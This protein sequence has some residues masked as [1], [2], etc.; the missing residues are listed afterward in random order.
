MEAD[1]VVLAVVLVTL[2]GDYILQLVASVLNY[3]ALGQPMPLE[4]SDVYDVAEYARSGEYTRAK[5]KFGKLHSTFELVVILLFWLP[6]CGFERVDSLVY[7]MV[8]SS[9]EGDERWRQIPRG[10]LFVGILSIA[11]GLLG[12]PWSIYSTFVLEERFG[13]NKTTV[14]T[15]VLDRLKGLALG[16][17]LGPPIGAAVLAFFLYTGPLAWLYCWAFMAAFQ[18]VLMWLLPVLLMPLFYQFTPIPEGPLQDAVK[19]YA[20]KVSFSFGGIFEVDGSTRSQHSNAFFTG[21]GSTKRIAIF[22]TLIKQ[23]ST[24]EIVAVL[25]HE[26]GHEKCGHIVKSIVVSLLYSLVLLYIMSLF[27]AFEPLFSA[28]CVTRPSVYVGLYLFQMLSS[29]IDHVLSLAMMVRSRANEFEADR[30]SVETNADAPSL[31]A[32]LK[33]LSSKNLDNL[34][35]HPLHVFLNY[36]HPPMAQRVAAIRVHAAK[37]GHDM[38]ADPQADEGE[39]KKDS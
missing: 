24:E 7:A 16:L 27:L 35:P 20:G 17:L 18:L 10:I 15:F 12:I 22:D 30:Y 13:F 36:S 2:I 39:A 14:K 31:V 23:A 25:A 38:S 33:K 28:F 29:P 6:F 11:D 3:R 19:S 32:A 9:G 1:D 37:L 4:F 21:F 34:T 26:I 5:T 8:P